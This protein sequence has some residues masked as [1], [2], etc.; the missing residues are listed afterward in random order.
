MKNV[1]WAGCLVI[2]MVTNTLWSGGDNEEILGMHAGMY[3]CMYIMYAMYPFLLSHPTSIVLHSVY[4]TWISYPAPPL[5]IWLL[6][7]LQYLYPLFWL[8]FGGNEK[9]LTHQL[10]YMLL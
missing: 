7:P 5:S 10:K 8:L 2:I 4:K 9:W 3:V 6:P 1:M